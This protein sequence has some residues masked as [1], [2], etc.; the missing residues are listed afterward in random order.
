MAFF[1]VHSTQI[2]MDRLSEHEV[3]C[4]ETRDLCGVY[5]PTS[6]QKKQSTGV[7]NQNFTIA[8]INVGAAINRNLESR[9]FDNA[10]PLPTVSQVLKECLADKW[11]NYCTKDQ[12]RLVCE[13]FSDE[14]LNSINPV[15]RPFQC[16]RINNLT[17]K[18]CRYIFHGEEIELEASPWQE[19]HNLPDFLRVS[20]DLQYEAQKILVSIWAKLYMKVS[21]IVGPDAWNHFIETIPVEETSEDIITRAALQTLSF[22]DGSSVQEPVEIQEDKH[23][24]T[25]V[26]EI[27]T[28]HAMIIGRAQIPSFKAESLSPLVFL[29]EFRVSDLYEGIIRRNGYPNAKVFYNGVPKKGIPTTAILVPDIFEYKDIELLNPVGIDKN[30]ICAIKLIRKSSGEITAVSF[31]GDC[32]GW[33]SLNDKISIFLNAQLDTTVFGGDYQGGKPGADRTLFPGKLTKTISTRIKPSQSQFGFNAGIK[34]IRNT[35]SKSD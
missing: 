4:G 29:Q 20:Q 1:V 26:G 30:R 18:I 31:H 23:L 22:L 2:F 34:A 35:W 28:D 16:D 9:S 8:S 24:C 27:V 17:E 25:Q 6:Q 10:T 7:Q 5:I 12:Q 32:N 14:Q 13:F 33:P 11:R 21:D 3:G 15:M 19:H